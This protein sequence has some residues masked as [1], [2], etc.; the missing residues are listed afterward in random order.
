M[1]RQQIT[2]I[3]ILDLLAVFDMV[4]YYKFWSKTSVFVEGSTLVSKLS[5]P[6][7]IGGQCQWK[8]FK[9]NGS[10]IQHSTG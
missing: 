4:E 10:Q 5:K 2:V 7:I 8:V 1:E 6:M 3:V 9:S